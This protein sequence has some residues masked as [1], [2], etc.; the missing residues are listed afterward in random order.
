MN[1]DFDL[2]KAEK[3]M[4][5][6]TSEDFFDKLEENIWKEIKDDYLA[7][8]PKEH[9]PQVLQLGYSAHCKTSKSR[10]IMR[11]II[12]VAASATLVFIV[13]MNF[14]KQATVSIN[15]VDNA[16]SQLSTDDQAYLLDVYQDDVFINE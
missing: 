12:A 14:S 11:S 9:A 8:K 7:E 5:Y 3:Q 13:N 15:D 1:K 6:T 4:P 16:F 10:F 2:D